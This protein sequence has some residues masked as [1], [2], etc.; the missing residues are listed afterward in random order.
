MVTAKVKHFQR[1]SVPPA[2][3]WIGVEKSGTIIC[4]HCDCMAGLGE[5][6]SHVAAILFTL[7]A[8]A[9]AKV[10]VLHI[11]AMLLVTSLL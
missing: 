11:N 10:F 7:E 6:C 1:L 3:A 9:Q 2:K 4:G 5:A 8:N